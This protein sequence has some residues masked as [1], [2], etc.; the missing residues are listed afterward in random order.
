MKRKIYLENIAFII[1]IMGIISIS[2]NNFLFMAV[3]LTW[4]FCVKYAL[5]HFKERV[6]LLVFLSVFF[7]F[8]IG[9]DFVQ[10]FFGYK[11]ENF[12]DEIQ[13][14]AHISLLISLLSL[15]GSYYF[16]YKLKRKKKK[17]EKKSY[18]RIREK[19]QKLSRIFFFVVLI[20]SCT[21]EIMLIKYIFKFSY[22]QYYVEYFKVLQSN[23]IL[24]LINKIE[25]LLPIILSIYL[26]TF[27]PK[28]EVR[29]VFHFYGLYLILSLG[30]GQRSKFILGVIYIF[31]YIVKRHSLSP[32]EKWFK[33]KYVIALLMISPILMIFLS[34]YS[35]WRMGISTDRSFLESL[36]SF[37]YEQGVSLNVIKRGYEYKYLVLP[38]HLYTLEFM[39]SGWI[40]RILGIPIYHGNT[41][42]HALYGGSYTHM[43]GYIVL[44][45]SYL[46]GLGIGSSYIAELFQDFGYIGIILGNILYGYLIVSIDNI[47]KNDIFWTSIKFTILQAL[48]WSIRASFSGFLTIL[49]APTT[50]IAFCIIFIRKKLRKSI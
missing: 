15:V 44:K 48:L 4:I 28:K 45:D 9:R 18:S 34:L 36:L 29:P 37:F 12:S 35:S 42:E 2:F 27:P 3:L 49:L 30:S 43:I 11:L 24:Y 23:L 5:R 21:S 10:V 25:L 38:N 6:M 16:F 8:L 1:L 47:K 50:M 17:K 14:Y 13:N 41:V 31:V 33:N 7:I 20:F 46:A 32:Y 40:A 19:T 39:K 22:I 26:S